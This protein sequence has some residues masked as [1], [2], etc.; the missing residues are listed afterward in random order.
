MTEPDKSQL[1][2]SKWVMAFYTR[3]AI[4]LQYEWDV[5]AECSD[6]NGVFRALAII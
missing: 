1:Q 4:C 6:S 3:T 2:L 5:D